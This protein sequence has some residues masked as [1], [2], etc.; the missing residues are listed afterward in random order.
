MTNSPKSRWKIHY[1]IFIPA[2]FGSLT[3][4]LSRKREREAA[5]GTRVD[6]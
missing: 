1:V 5:R 6:G 3:P 4:P 2:V